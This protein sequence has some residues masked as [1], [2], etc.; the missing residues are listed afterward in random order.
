MTLNGQTLSLSLFLI[1]AAYTGMGLLVWSRRPG[2]AITSFAWTMFSLAVWSMGYGLEFLTPLLS[3]KMT[4]ASLEFLGIASVAVFIFHFSVT[5]TGRRSL[6][7]PANR[8]LLWVIPVITIILAWTN[9]YH[10]LIWRRSWIEVASGVEVFVAEFGTWFWLQILFS[11]LL[12]FVG[13]GL[14]ILEM[15]RSPMPYRLRAGI[16]LVG[17]AFPWIGSL[18]YLSE[19]FLPGVDLTLFFFLP[20][21]LLMA[22]GIL[23]YH[24]LGILPMAPAMV[25]HDMDDGILVVDARQRILYLNRAVAGILGIKIDQALGQPLESLLPDIA[26]MHLHLVE[27][28]EPY[29]EREFM[30]NGASRTFDVRLSQ[31]SAEVRGAKSG[32]KGGLMVFRDIHRRKQ[33][34]VELQNREAILGAINL[35]AQQFLRTTSWESN[36]PAFLE[37]LGQAVGSGRT[38]IFQNYCKENGQLHTRQTYE[39]TAHGISAQLGNRKFQN[40]P[41]TQIGPEPW[42]AQ[43]HQ[44]KLV[45]A[46]TSQ[47]LVS[48]SQ[49]MVERKV[50]STT[51]VPIFVEGQWWGILGMEDYAHERT[52]ETAELEALR[53]AADIVG[54]AEIRV[55]NEAALQ[56]RQRAL[57]LQHEIVVSAL[58]S[59][60]LETMAQNLVDRLTELV[61]ADGC[62]VTLWDAKEKRP[63]P[64]GA[65]GRQQ[66]I[67]QAHPLLYGKNTLTSKVLKSGSTL[68]IE[69][70]ADQSFRKRHSSPE[71]PFRSALILPLIAGKN[72]LG[73]IHLVYESLHRFQEQEITS[74]EQAAGLI[75]LALEKFQAVE[76]ASRRA[77]ASE[78]IRMASA[79]VVETLR[80]EEAVDRILEQLLH[81]VPYDSASVQLIRDNELEIVGGRG[82]D[83]PNA[84]IGLRFPVPGDNPNTVVIQTGTPKILHNAGEVYE[85]FREGPHSHIRSWLGV[86]LIV[87]GQTIGLLAID[88]KHQNFFTTEHINTVS[89][90]ADHVAI[91][92]ENA[93]LFE[94]SEKNTRQQ[95]ALLLLSAELSAALTEAEIYRIVTRGLHSTLGYDHVGIFAVE[96]V[97]GDRVLQASIGWPDAP[98]DWRIPVGQGV[99]ENSIRDGQLHYY[100]DVS[101]EPSYIP[102][103]GGSEVNIPIWMGDKIGAVM[104]VEDKQTFAFKQDDLDLLSVAANLTGLALTRGRLFSIE[105]NQYEEL[106][107]FHAIALAVSEAADENQLLEHVTQVI[108]ENLF[109]DNFGILMVDEALG[110]FKVHSSYH[111]NREL[112]GKETITPLDQGVVGHVFETGMP[113]NLADV[114]SCSYYLN[115]DSTTRS[116]LAVPLRLGKRVIGVINAESTK[117]NAFSDS[118]ERLLTTLAGQLATAIDR[119][120]TTE[121]ERQRSTQLAHSNALI[122]AL[123][124]VAARISSASDLDGVLDTLGKELQKLHFTCLVALTTADHQKLRSG[125]PPCPAIWSNYMYAYPATNWVS[126]ASLSRN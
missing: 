67:Y 32:E 49:E 5:Y 117:S 2:L 30:L 69:D 21:S 6:L 43:L 15:I 85:A 47:M 97:T 74:G 115:I 44:R 103:I 98:D 107:V 3:R 119:L 20:T 104:S 33:A 63:K 78:T 110:E 96:E 93:R 123:G 40:I 118:D 125:T 114:A 55:R 26:D 106:A 29:L 1:A 111:I 76:D 23:R 46:T 124:Q 36:I 4:W 70:T 35:A 65:T 95:S 11:Y 121:M 18:L 84:I 7:T 101:K 52:W 99:T 42:S 48:E 88:S 90:F 60:D 108:G 37:R 122:E 22:W 59:S 62:L 81:V 68:V 77:E 80:S 92:L 57:S 71:F 100:P 112:L 45:T 83:D 12:L 120:R 72:S 102:G 86:P 113:E 109:P 27:Q 13:F 51:L 105:R 54:A 9:P 58:Q 50:L 73:A 17:T 38:F 116:E 75:A 64:L 82:W 56:S 16:L 28:R 126:S 31:M 14:L 91:A 39:W 61:R 66:E 24:L 19:S 10:H 25:L 34:E 8:V 89:T 41:I 79:S 94:T 53:A 87:S